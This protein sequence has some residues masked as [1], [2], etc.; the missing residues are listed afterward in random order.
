MLIAIDRFVVLWTK[1]SRRKKIVNRSTIRQEI[2]L[3]T[4]PLNVSAQFLWG[5]C[6]LDG[7]LSHISFRNIRSPTCIHSVRL[8]SKSVITIFVTKWVAFDRVVE[9]DA[10]AWFYKQTD[11]FVIG[12]GSLMSLLQIELHICGS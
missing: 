10:L 5:L 7:L 9:V 3:F 4:P 2:V 6:I 11:F 12:R 1:K 8:D